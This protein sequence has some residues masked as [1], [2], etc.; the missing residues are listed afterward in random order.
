V[1]ET[2]RLLLGK[3]VFGDTRN[4]LVLNAVYE[5]AVFG[6]A[7]DCCV[8]INGLNWHLCVAGVLNREE[9]ETVVALKGLNASGKLPS[10]VLSGGKASLSSGKAIFISGLDIENR[11]EHPRQVVERT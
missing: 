1:L 11:T 8:C 2:T 6:L 3:H 7:I 10:G 4:P 9:S 5:K